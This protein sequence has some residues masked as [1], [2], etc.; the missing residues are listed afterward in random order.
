M[1]DIDM[2]DL[3]GNELQFQI[4]LNWKFKVIKIRYFDLKV[5][6]K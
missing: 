2:C 3:N 4:T 6:S 1:N 5:G